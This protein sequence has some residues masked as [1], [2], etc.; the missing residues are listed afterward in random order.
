MSVDMNYSVSVHSQE[1]FFAS[2][3]ITRQEASTVMYPTVIYPAINILLCRQ[4]YPP[5]IYTYH[6]HWWLNSLSLIPTLEEDEAHAI[7]IYKSGR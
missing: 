6:L 2:I 4:V 7:Y 5:F 1:I 3:R